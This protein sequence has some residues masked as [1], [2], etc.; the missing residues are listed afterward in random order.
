MSTPAH[1][2][3]PQLGNSQPNFS[4]MGLSAAEQRALGQQ[5]DPGSVINEFREQ[6]G[7]EQNAMEN[8][9]LQRMKQ[10]SDRLR[11][12]LGQSQQA[13]ADMRS[14]HDTLAGQVSAMQ[15]AQYAQNQQAQHESQYGLTQDEMDNHGELLPLINKV[16]GRTQ[17]EAQAKYQ[18]QLNR[19]QE[20]TAAPLQTEIAQ[21]RQRAELQEAQAKTQFAASLN[22]EIAGMGLGNINDLVKNQ[23][24]LNRHGKS[25]Y[26]GATATWGATLT[27]HINEGDLATATAMLEDFR[28][29]SESYKPREDSVVP[30]GRRPASQPMSTQS[31]QNLNKRDHLVSIYQQR[32]EDANNGTFP[33]GMSRVQYKQAQT[34]L[35][36]EIDSIPTT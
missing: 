4:S 18:D 2:I 9:E 3:D 27:Q 22:K 5:V 23:E 11:A 15:N 29:S 14:G 7:R 1:L 30:T 33:Q 31:T 28:D 36:N 25:L 35:Q 34:A 26:P 12:E 24:F 32:M 10:D 13:L 21:L 17:S 6:D 20:Q 19:M 8:Y 16:V